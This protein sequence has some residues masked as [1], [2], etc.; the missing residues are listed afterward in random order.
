MDP[1]PPFAGIKGRDRGSRPGRFLRPE[2]AS[3]AFDM[4]VSFS[5]SQLDL[6]TALLILNKSTVRWGAVCFP[7]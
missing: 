6:L 3:E 1:R 4:S 5:E 7:G 2:Y